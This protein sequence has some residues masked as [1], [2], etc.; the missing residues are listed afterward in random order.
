M[1]GEHLL[2]LLQD[3]ID[4]ILI[5]FTEKDDRH[6]ENIVIFQEDCAPPHFAQPVRQYLDATFSGRC[7][8]IRDIEW[9]PGSQDLSPLDLFL[10]GYLESK[11]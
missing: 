3:I 2:Q 1:L 4:S 5:Y 10:S 7:M 11:I 8:G 6:F 9:P